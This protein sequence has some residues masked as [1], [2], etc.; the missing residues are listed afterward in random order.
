MKLVLFFVLAGV[1]NIFA[2]FPTGDYYS[3]FPD[4]AAI[5][6]IDSA[7]IKL[8]GG[9]PF[10]DQATKTVRIDS[11]KEGNRVMITKLTQRS[12]SNWRIIGKLADTSLTT[13]ALLDITINAPETFI[14]NFLKN[15]YKTE[16]DA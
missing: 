9:V 16:A 6:T 15:E 4:K 11:A 14:L 13:Y 8:N 3:I 2:Q 5:V 12:P 1:T 10:F 7:T